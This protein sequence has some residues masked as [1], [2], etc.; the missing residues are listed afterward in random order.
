MINF[1]HKPLLVPAY[2]KTKKYPSV[3]KVI[4]PLSEEGLAKWRA[5]VGDAEADRIM[6][7][8][9]ARGNS[10]HRLV[11]D[12]VN[13]KPVDPK[14]ESFVVKNIYSQVSTHLIG[15]VTHILGQELTLWSDVLKLNGRLD[16]LAKYDDEI[17]IIDHK[18]SIKPKPAE[19]LQS[20]F[21]QVSLYSAMLYERTGMVVKKGV[22]IIGLEDDIHPQV[23]NVPISKYINSSI[24][25][26]KKYHEGI[27]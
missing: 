25:L 5:R 17:S 21:H 11:E 8:A 9:G 23:V 18:S 20:Y 3:S 26:V 13:N 12:L 14:Y 24:K 4:A 7:A 19:H 6:K 2:D 15:H 22:L 27:K 16:L 10:L 1:E